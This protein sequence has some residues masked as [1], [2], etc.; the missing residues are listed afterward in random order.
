MT[1]TIA[2]TP[3]T[4]LLKVVDPAERLKHYKR[5]LSFYARHLLDGTFDRLVFV[6][7]SGYPLDD[8]VAT[9]ACSNIA[10]L[11]E[12]ISYNSDVSPHNSRYYL[13]INLLRFT[14]MTSNTI[15]SNPEAVIWKITGRYI[16]SNIA[17]IVA[18]TSRTADLHLNLRNYPHRTLD[19]YLVGYRAASFF[20]HIGHDIEGYKTIRNGEEMLRKKVDEGAFKGIEIDPRFRRTPRLFGVRGFDGSRYGGTNDTLKYIARSLLNAILPW[21]WI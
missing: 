18:T 5:A 12:F 21:V 19:F 2:P 4:F 7:N 10:E 9:A 1:S 13:E 3:N 17:S 15:L 8:L 16:V 20:Q 14:M 6:D 11:V